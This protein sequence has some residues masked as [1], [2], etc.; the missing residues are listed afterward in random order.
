MNCYL[1][2]IF[3]IVLASDA[4]AFRVLSENSWSPNPEPAITLAASY[5]ALIA[6]I[7]LVH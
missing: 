5:D 6:L 3:G 7:E 1:W 2:F 4:L